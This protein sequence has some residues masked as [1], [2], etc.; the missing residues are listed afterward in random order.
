MEMILPQQQEYSHL[1]EGIEHCAVGQKEKAA[2]AT[3]AAFSSRENS[4]NGNFTI[5]TFL[6]KSYEPERG[7]SSDFSRINIFVFND[8]EYS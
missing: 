1:Y 6:G 8:L 7:V 4:P 3:R 2:R 5:K